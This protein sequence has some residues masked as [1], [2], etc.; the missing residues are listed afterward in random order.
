MDDEENKT[1][2]LNSDNMINDEMD[3]EEIDEMEEFIDMID[4]KKIFYLSISDGTVIP[5]TNP[6]YYV[7]RK[8]IVLE[9]DI[10][11]NKIYNAKA[12]IE[13]ETYHVNNT[14]MDEI[15]NFTKEN[16]NRLIQIAINQTT[17][18]YSGGQLSIIIKIGS[19]LITLSP[20]NAENEEDIFFL[21][22]F[23]NKIVEMIVNN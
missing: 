19:I 22:Q 1:N 3:E 2:I 18:T 23:E 17:E 14:K 16:L 10:V 7:G 20:S 13:K 15:I 11:L 8:D 21:K 5:I 9:K 6:N 4:N 12:N